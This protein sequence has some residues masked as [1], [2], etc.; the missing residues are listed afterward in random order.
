MGKGDNRRPARVDDRTFEENWKL[1]FGSTIKPEDTDEK[2]D[3]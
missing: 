3:D 1:A 2:E